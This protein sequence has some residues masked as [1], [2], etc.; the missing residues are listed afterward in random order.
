MNGSILLFLGIMAVLVVSGC[1]DKNQEDLSSQRGCSYKECPEG[2]MQY[3]G[4]CGLGPDGPVTCP[5]EI[6]EKQDCECHK[7]CGYD[8]SVCPP[9]APNC[10]EV[11]ISDTQVFLCFK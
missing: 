4:D 3:A 10:E 1:V 8:D 2:Y 9:E 6:L 5:P 11:V 7:E